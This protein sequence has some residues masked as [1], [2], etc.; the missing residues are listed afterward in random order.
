[1]LLN[2]A[3]MAEEQGTLAEE[4]ESLEVERA[5]RESA[6]LNYRQTLAFAF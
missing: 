4:I 3:A 6:L 2:L 5:F 1:L